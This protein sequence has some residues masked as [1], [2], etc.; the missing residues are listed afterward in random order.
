[1]IRRPPIST[2][3]PYTT[4]FRS[5]HVV[6]EHALEAEAEALGGAAGRRV[7][8]VALPLEPAVAKLVEGVAGRSGKHT[9]ELPSR[10]YL[11]IRVFPL[12]KKLRTSL[13]QTYLSRSI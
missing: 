1:M 10:H 6:A 7:Q 11:I 13:S 2:L 12:K 3:F 4:L 9:F 5:H 8:G